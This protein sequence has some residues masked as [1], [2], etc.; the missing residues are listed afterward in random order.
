MHA[1]VHLMQEFL[2]NLFGG[3]LVES[4]LRTDPEQQQLLVRDQFNTRKMILVVTRTGKVKD[5]LMISHPASNHCSVL[6][7]W[8]LTIASSGPT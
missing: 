3:K 6:S 7:L 4:I 1:C 5:N 8:N 2:Q